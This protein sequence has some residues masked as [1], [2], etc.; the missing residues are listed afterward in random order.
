VISAASLNERSPR[1]NCCPPQHSPAPDPARPA[2]GPPATRPAAPDRART[3]APH[4]PRSDA[5]H[6]RGIKHG[7]TAPGGT[8]VVRSAMGACGPARVPGR[9]GYSVTAVQ[10][11]TAEDDGTTCP[12]GAQGPVRY[13][14]RGP[15]TAVPCPAAVSPA[16]PR[17]STPSHRQ[18]AAS[19]AAAGGAQPHEGG[20]SAR[21][22]HPPDR[23]EPPPRSLL[24]GSGPQPWTKNQPTPVD[25]PA[26]PRSP[27]RSRY[28]E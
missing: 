10:A 22:I 20:S 25:C 21:R 15:D 9:R 6:P 13:P 8:D 19:V 14:G 23:R 17:R 12:T 18:A 3:P 28:S 1:P 26:L 5:P 2:C 16:R 7:G 27:S 11:A 24:N 4:P